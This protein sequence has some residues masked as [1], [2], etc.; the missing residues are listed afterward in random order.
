LGREAAQKHMNDEFV[1]CTMEDLKAISK[2]LSLFFLRLQKFYYTHV[3]AYTG[4]N[5]AFK[6]RIESS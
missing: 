5:Q 4:F 1:P 2:F 3:S 6:K